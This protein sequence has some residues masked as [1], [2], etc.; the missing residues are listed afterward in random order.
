MSKYFL[1]NE[2][3]LYLLKSQIITNKHIIVQNIGDI[4][5]HSHPI[6]PNAKEIIVRNCDK[7]YVYYHIDDRTFP[8]LKNLYLL[9][10]PC[11][12]SFFI[13]F[14]KPE[15]KILLSNHYK[16]YKE[17]WAKNRTDVILIDP[18]II[19]QK[20]GEIHPKDY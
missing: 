18:E 4:C 7:N 11:E 9:S 20:I 16:E 17:R 19:T 2:A 12:P 15:Q 1:L 13:R 5:L 3:N 8:N 6:F 10:H 14:T